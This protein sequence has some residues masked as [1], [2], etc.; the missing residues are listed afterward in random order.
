[1]I[2]VNTATGTYSK[3]EEY[4]SWGHLA[5]VVRTG[6][7]RIASTSLGN[8]GIETVPSRIRRVRWP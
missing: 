2:T 7:V 4:Y 3:N 8:G 6:A 5:K 1:M